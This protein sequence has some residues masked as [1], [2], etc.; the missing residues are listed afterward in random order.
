MTV[1][2]K[3]EVGTV[4][5]FDAL[6]GDCKGQA[7]KVL[8]EAAEAVEAWKAMRNASAALDEGAEREREQLGF[9]GDGGMRML[10][11]LRAMS[12][13]HLADEVADV[14]QASCNLAFACGIDVRAA[15]DRCEERNRARGRIDG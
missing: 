14:I 10:L 13:E 5:V 8:E 2:R 4:R 15:L 7:V 1:D 11:D 6:V 12:A 9:V 3:V